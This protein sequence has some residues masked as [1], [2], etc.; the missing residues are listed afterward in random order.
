[1]HSFRN[2]AVALLVFA[3]GLGFISCPQEAEAATGPRIIISEFSISP[4]PIEPGD[5]FDATV[6]LR[7]IGDQTAANIELAINE[8]AVSSP[9][10][11]YLISNTVSVQ[12]KSGR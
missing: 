7:N 2:F 12:G 1:M 6:T 4:E 10:A 3:A 11:P 8:G 9:F 5:D